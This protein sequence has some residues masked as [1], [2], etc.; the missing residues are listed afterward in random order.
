MT[1]ADLATQVAKKA[2]LTNKAAKDAVN[3]V[4]VIT[5][6]ISK[7][8]ASNDRFLDILLVLYLQQLFLVSV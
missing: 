3:A 2:G 5:P 7:I 1:K 8:T 4:F 6:S